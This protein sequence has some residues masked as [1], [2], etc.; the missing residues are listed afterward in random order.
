MTY[1][2]SKEE[3]GQRLDAYLASLSD[4]SLSRS[5]AARLCEA[6]AVSVNGKPADKKTRLSEG[7][8]IDCTPPPTEDIPVV[9]QDIP[10]D[11]IY[12]DE[13]ILVLNKPAGMVVHPAPGN[14]D[15]TV[16]NALLHHCGDSLSGINGERRPGIVHR[17]DKDTSGLLAVAKNDM[18]HR[19]LARQLEDHTMY[20]EYRA[21]VRGGFHEEEGTIDA[22][23]GRHPK[24][25][26]K[27]AVLL[28][29]HHT[30]RRAVT[31]WRVLE[32]FGQV[33]YLALRLETGRT[34]Q[35]RC[36][37]SYIGHPL[38]GDTV[39]GGGNTPFEKKHAALLSGQVLH[40]VSLSFLHP[41]TNE[42]MTFSCP[43]P[44]NFLR[45]LDILRSS[46]G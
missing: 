16:V 29:G 28:D 22:P 33:T 10:L 17:I 43:L 36:H 41:R 21:L 45:L 46:C 5:A 32:P 40:A 14:P 11:I 1:L 42:R 19:A 44:E 39:Y 23:I 6:G 27:M 18:A 15:G 30:A 31:H 13:D 26:L 37:M 25:R 4:L 38:L 9:A 7:D 34:H 2:I 35:I 20:R 12:E 8:R 3:A 24:D